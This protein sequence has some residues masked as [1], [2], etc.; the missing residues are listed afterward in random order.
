[1]SH[2]DDLVELSNQFRER[3]RV[4][5][6]NQHRTRNLLQ[7]ILNILYLIERRLEPRFTLSIT[8]IV[9]LEEFIKGDTR[10]MAAITAGQ[11]ASFFLSATASDN[12]TVVL[13]SQ[14]LTADDPNVSIAPDTTDST[15]NIFTVTVPASDTATT[16]NLNATA[17]ATSNTSTIPQSV[18]ATL[19]V[20]ISPASVPVSFTLQIN[21]K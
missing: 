9:P 4:L 11:S 2:H 8:Q 21:E 6:Q 20:T 15:G 3:C 16:F 12:S 18:S 14:A 5:N 10:F 7:E 1:M 19:P 13:A 17:S